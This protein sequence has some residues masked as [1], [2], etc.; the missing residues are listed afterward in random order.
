MSEYEQGSQVVFYANFIDFKGNP[1][2]LTGTPQI[3][4]Y[5]RYGNTTTKDIDYENMSQDSTVPSSYYYKYHI[6][7]GADKSTYTV[8]YSGTYSDGTNGINT[9]D[10][11]VINKKFFDKKGGG[12]VQKITNDNIWSK[13]EKEQVLDFLD[14]IREANNFL[15]LQEKMDKTID[16]LSLMSKGLSGNNKSLEEQKE[17]LLKSNDVL[18]NLKNN[19]S[20]TVVQ[21]NEKEIIENIESVSKQVQEL[22]DDLKKEKI[23]MVV[24]QLDDLKKEIGENKNDFDDFQQF[25]VSILSD[26]I[27][28]KVIQCK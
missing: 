3:I 2:V 8:V 10:F 28:E 27:M 23:E 18:A 21:F 5:H 24:S 4:M 17:L 7:V 15:G 20:E 13:K 25:F 12:F 22:G 19:S 16:S 9:E 6:P 1:A 26:K 14:K 11:L